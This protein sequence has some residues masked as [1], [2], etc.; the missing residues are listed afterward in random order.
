MMN[1]GRFFK[2]FETMD[3]ANECADLSGNAETSCRLI[4][5]AVNSRNVDA[6]STEGRRKVDGEST[7]L[8]PPVSFCRRITQHG[9]RT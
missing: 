5:T 1:P 8:R 3:V 2:G 9:K 6:E 4:S 7:L